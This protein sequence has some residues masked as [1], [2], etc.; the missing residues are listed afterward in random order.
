M[1][2]ASAP[3]VAALAVV[4][5]AGCSLAASSAEKAHVVPAAVVDPASASKSCRRCAK[6]WGRTTSSACVCRATSC[7]RAAWRRMNG[8]PR[9][10]AAWLP[11]AKRHVPASR[12]VSGAGAGEGGADAADGACAGVA[13][14]PF[15]TVVNGGSGADSGAWPL[16]S[17][18]AT[19]SVTRL[20]GG[21]VPLVPGWCP[22]VEGRSLRL[23]TAVDLEFFLAMHWYTN[24]QREQGGFAGQGANA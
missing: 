11:L 12:P 14:S 4:F 13:V 17:T 8:L 16:A 19:A 9:P 15:G 24:P 20:T 1:R 18:A 3:I 23:A 10:L 21:C 7:W 2:N 22:F 5:A 6:P